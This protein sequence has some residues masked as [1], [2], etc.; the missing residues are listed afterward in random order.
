MKF[1][2]INHDYR[3]G[4]WC[5][6][7]ALA[8]ITGRPTSECR[9]A[10]IA[11]RG[12]HRGFGTVHH[13]TGIHNWELRKAFT[14]LGY[15][16]LTCRTHEHLPMKER[17]TLA[18][19]LRGR[20]IG[21]RAEMVVVCI[22]GHYVTVKGRSFVDNFTREPINVK[23]APHRRA[24]VET[25]WMIRKSTFPSTW[26]APVK[27]RPIPNR[28]RPQAIALAAANGITLDYSE[29]RSAGCIW[30]TCDKAEACGEDIYEKDGHTV[31]SW[32]DALERVKG[33]IGVLQS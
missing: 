9:A 1:H 10:I 23:D 32:E 18:Q 21:L 8:T 12:D 15:D 16:T 11:A 4:L 2:P 27:P 26:R 7:A 6:I 25:A 30:V 3:A 19:F 31:E 29:Y 24:R 13:V 17:P 22:T 20:T 28:A 14:L 5:G 33:Y